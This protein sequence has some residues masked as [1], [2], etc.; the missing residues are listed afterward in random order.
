MQIELARFSSPLIEPLNGAVDQLL[1]ELAFSIRTDQQHRR[2]ITILKEG[3]RQL[4]QP[5]SS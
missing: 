4:H 1:G 5:G 2:A 3:L